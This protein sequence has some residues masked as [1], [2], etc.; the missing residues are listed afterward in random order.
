VAGIDE[1]GIGADYGGQACSASVKM[2]FYL[3]D[4]QQEFTMRKM[5]ML[6]LASFVWK[7]VQ[8]RMGRMPVSRGVPRR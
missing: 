2:H 8:K 1:I 4:Q 6:A 3:T 7:Q 5:I